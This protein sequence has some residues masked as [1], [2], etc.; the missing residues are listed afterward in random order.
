MNRTR[1]IKRTLVNVLVLNW[2]VALAKIILGAAINSSSMLADGFHSFSDGASNIVGLVGI[3][4]ASKPV[5]KEHLY[6]HKKYE[7]IA[8]LAIAMLLILLCL[9]I[10]RSSI[11]RFYNPITPSV[12]R[13]SFVVMFVTMVINFSVAIY[14]YRKGKQVKSDIL[15]S[16]SMHTA[17][18]IFTSLS[19]IIALIAV[20]LGYPIVDTISSVIIVLFIAYAAFRILHDCCRVLSDQVVLDTRKIAKVVKNIEGVITCHKIRSRGRKDDIHIDLHVLVNK[21]MHIDKAHDLSNKIERELKVAFP[22]VTDI[23]VHLEPDTRKKHRGK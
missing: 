6:G 11:L 1:E 12:N 8:S 15:V 22:G 7:T 2:L 23:V 13:L 18:D 19:V 14:E 9:N 5:D 17:A 4:F 21:D 20:K 10:L 3:G 16:D